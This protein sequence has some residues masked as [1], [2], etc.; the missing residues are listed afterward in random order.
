[1]KKSYNVAGTE[2]KRIRKKMEGTQKVSIYR[3]LE[4]V[5]LLVEGKKPTEIA[6]ITHY[7]EKSVRNLGLAYQA[8]GLDAFATDGRKGGNHRI[9]SKEEA[10][11]FLKRFEEEAMSGK[12]IT[13]NEITAELD[14]V[15]GKNSVSLSSTYAFCMHMAG[16]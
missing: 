14:K 10:E 7:S 2:A 1:M 13:V 9:M 15:T 16:E 5:A 12:I 11:A 8:K 4:V 6:Q 3:R